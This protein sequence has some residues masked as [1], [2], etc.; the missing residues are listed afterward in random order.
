MHA[1]TAD[2]IDL[3]KLHKDEYAASS[4]P[5]LIRIGKAHYL[6]A[7]GRGAPGGET[8][9]S[10]LQALYGTAYTLK[11]ASKFAG[12]DFVVG[13]LEGLYGVDGQAP[14]DLE[15]LP[16]EQWNWR[17]MI[18]VPDGIQAR[19]LADARRTLRDKGKAGDFD[20]VTL[21]AVEEGLCVQMMHV[22][23]Y[24]EEARTVAAMRELARAHDLAPHRWHH[25]I[26]LGDPRR[27]PPAKLRTILRQPVR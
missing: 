17:M 22:G 18:R 27:V 19:Q 20:A 12:H 24:E 10:R 13:K 5:A 6:V 16:H 23:P 8:F 25:E 21:E 26:Y 4:K 11:F 14:D 2:K 7:R 1:K 9:Q 3:F 15:R